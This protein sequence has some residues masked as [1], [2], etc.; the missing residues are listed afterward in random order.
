M[1]VMENNFEMFFRAEI[2]RVLV[3]DVDP[4]SS[5][6]WMLKPDQIVTTT[7]FAVKMSCSANKLHASLS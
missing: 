3:V 2:S 4:S 1:D 7:I 6:R 5:A